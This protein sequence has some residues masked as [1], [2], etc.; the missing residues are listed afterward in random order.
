M[1]VIIYDWFG[2]VDDVL[3]M[4]DL[5]IFVFG[6]GEVLVWLVI[7]GVNLFDICVRVGGWFG[8]VKLLFLKII[9][10]SDG[11]GL[12]EVVGDGVLVICIGERVWIWNG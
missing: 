4:E 10:Y 11:V 1:C 8:V 6:F 12:I 3:I 7:L 2:L 5:L 9:L